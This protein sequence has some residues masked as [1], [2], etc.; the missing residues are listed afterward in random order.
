ML[1]NQDEF[2]DV[3]ALEGAVPEEHSE[4]HHTEGPDISFDRIGLAFEDF[5][6]H[7]DGRSEHGFWDLVLSLKGFAES[8]IS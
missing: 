7:I 8:K 3:A 6:G 1:D 5:W 2:G 4:E